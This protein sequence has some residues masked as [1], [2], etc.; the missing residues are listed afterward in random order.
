V[1]PELRTSDAPSKAQNCAEIEILPPLPRP[2]LP[3][4]ALLLLLLLRDRM[5][6]HLRACM[7]QDLLLAAPLPLPF[8][9]LCP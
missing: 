8:P 4:H 3:L 1:L 9:P 6:C 2:H 5:G 7:R